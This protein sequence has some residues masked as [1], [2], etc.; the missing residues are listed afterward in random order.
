MPAAAA[1]GVSAA[2]TAIGSPAYAG[3]AVSSGLS[4]SHRQRC[5]PG[6]STARTPGSARAASRSSAVTRPCATGE[7]STA[8]V[9]HPRQRDVDGVAR[10]AAARDRPVLAR[11]RPA[12]DA[13]SA[14]SGQVS[15]LVVLVDE[16]P[17]RPRSA[18]PSR[19]ADLTSRGSR[20]VLPRGAQD[21]A[22]DLRV[23][24]AAAE[25]ARH[26]RADLLAGRPRAARAAPSRT[27]SDPACRSRTGARPRRR[28]PPG[29][30]RPPSRERPSIVVTRGPRRRPPAGGTRRPG[31]RRAARRTRRTR[32]R[33]SRASS[34]SARGRRAA[35]ASSRRVGGTSSDV[36][37]PLTSSVT[38]T[39]Q[40]VPAPRSARQLPSVPCARQSSRHRRRRAGA[41]SRG[42][43]A[44][45][46]SAASAASDRAGDDRRRRTA[47]AR[48][49]RR[50]RRARTAAR[51]QPT[52]RLDPEKTWTL[53]FETS[54]GTFVVTL[55]TRRRRPPRRRRSSPS[56]SRAS[57]T[58]RSSTAS[59]PAS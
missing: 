48:A 47:G 43:A 15:T 5:R 51:P 28:T 56:P 26:R 58:T 30:S 39:L 34:R 40:A 13:S 3:S 52:E 8:R 4:P 36:R 46:D 29:A 21:R 41:R 17:R 23:G 45:S 11:R 18:P 54:C 44:T 2:T 59:S 35:R 6:P 27:R 49:S 22:L 53:R 31:G 32:P 24:A 57:S 50:P 10:R 38:G 12:D 20:D 25:V 19:A 9:E 14:S 33:R 42:A 55:D 7:R 37:S 16:R 1:S